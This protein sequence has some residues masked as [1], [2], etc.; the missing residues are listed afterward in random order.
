MSGLRVVLED[1]TDAIKD[2]IL[3]IQSPV[4]EAATKAVRTAGDATKRAGRLDI[5]AAGFGSKW[6]NTLRVN[7]FPK[8]GASIDAAAFVFHKIPYSVVFE[9]GATIRGKPLLWV[10]LKTTPTKGIGRGKTTPKMLAGKGL[11]LFTIK[12]AGKPPLLAA[13]IPAFNPRARRKERLTLSKVR[14]AILGKKSSQGKAV[15]AVPLF[16]GIS[17]VHIRKKFHITQIAG[18]QRDAL[19]GY[20]VANLKV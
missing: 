6:Q 3:A 13:D 15:R 10:P 5:A 16:V 14:S 1:V 4:A 20:Y 18:G 2:S 7:Y 12:R 19:G 11:K 8:S 9:E 17:T